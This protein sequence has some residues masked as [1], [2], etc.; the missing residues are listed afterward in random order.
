[1]GFQPS[2]VDQMS[3]WEFRA[4]QAGWLK[5]NGAEDEAEPPS[6]EEHLEMVRKVKAMGEVS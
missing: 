5:A 4:C 3:L 1:M 6:W 2:I